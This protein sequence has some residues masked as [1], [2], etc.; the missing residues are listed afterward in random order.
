M[1]EC[2]YGF[3]LFCVGYVQLIVLYLVVEEHNSASEFVAILS[4]Y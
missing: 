1:N 4:V 2:C 3:Q